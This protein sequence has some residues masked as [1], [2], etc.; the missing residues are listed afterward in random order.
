MFGRKYWSRPLKITSYNR[1]NR[2][3]EHRALTLADREL[4]KV[5]LSS[6]VFTLIYK[7]RAPQVNYPTAFCFKNCERQF[8]VFLLINTIYYVLSLI[9]FLKWVLAV[10]EVSVKCV[11]DLG[12]GRNIQPVI[13]SPSCIQITKTINRNI[14]LI[15][16]EKS[17]H[18]R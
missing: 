2:Q 3:T 16:R 11:P 15:N 10:G 6:S 5:S 13:F 4:S 18:N 1:V 12:L 8:E 14:C 7:K 9:F 17:W